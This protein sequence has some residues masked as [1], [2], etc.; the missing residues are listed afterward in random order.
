MTDTITICDVIDDYTQCR[1]YGYECDG[2]E[3][4]D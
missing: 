3:D 2:R 1:L 4:D